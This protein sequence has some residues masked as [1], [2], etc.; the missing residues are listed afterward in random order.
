MLIDFFDQGEFSV[1]LMDDFVDGI[2]VEVGK[3]GIFESFYMVWMFL[4]LWLCDFIYVLVIC[5]YMMGEVLLVFDL[6]FWNGDGINLLV[7]MVVEYFCG[8]CQVNVFV[9]GGFDVVGG[10]VKIVDVDV[11]VCVIVCE[12][13]YIVVWVVFYYGV[14]QMGLKDKIFILLESGYIVGIVNL[15]SKKKYGYYFNDN[16]F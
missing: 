5:S 6:L 9:D 15:F 8:L 4:Y 1:F 7:K 16:L 2:E 11:F 10:I 13:D 12:I 14:L 3:Q